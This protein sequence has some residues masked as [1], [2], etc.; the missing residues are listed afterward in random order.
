MLNPFFVAVVGQMD[1]GQNHKSLWVATSNSSIKNW[2]LNPNETQ[3]NLEKKNSF[4][5]AT[6]KSNGSTVTS[7]NH[8][9]IISKNDE[10]SLGNTLSSSMIDS[11]S[12]T[13]SLSSSFLMQTPLS[14]QSLITIKGHFKVYML[15]HRHVT[16]N[17]FMSLYIFF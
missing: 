15:T 14:S 1:F 12:D 6:N 16:L 17:I 7:L 9:S 3:S 13:S 11:K 8:V 2:S 10:N 5:N 4:G